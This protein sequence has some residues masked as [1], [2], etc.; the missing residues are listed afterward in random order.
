MSTPQRKWGTQ[1]AMVAV[2]HALIALKWLVEW[3]VPDVPQEVRTE[4]RTAPRTDRPL[5][6]Y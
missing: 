4:G 3:A 2:E 5:D 1:V 6:L